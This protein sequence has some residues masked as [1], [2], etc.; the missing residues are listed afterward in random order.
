MAWVSPQALAAGVRPGLPVAEARSLAAAGPPAGGAP[1]ASRRAPQAWHWLESDPRAD[2]EELRAW[3]GWCERFSPLVALDETPEP[4][5]LLLDVSGCGPHFGG[6]A[7]LVRQLVGDLARQGLAARAALA[8]TW[9]AA[10]GWARHGPV[11]GEPEWRGAFPAG[12]APGWLVVDESRRAAFDLLPVAA[13]RL[14]SATL[15]RLAELGI[16]SIG[17]VRA[18][19]RA[20]LAARLGSEVLLRLDQAGG[21]RGEL[22]VSQRSDEPLVAELDFD[23][24]THD[25]RQLEAAWHEL[26]A[27]LR[28][29]L[30]ARGQQVRELVCRLAATPPVELALRL[31]EPTLSVRHLS[32][33][34]AL[35]LERRRLPPEVRG[36]A[37]E[38]TA[39]APLVDRQRWLVPEAAEPGGDRELAALCDRLTSRLGPAGVLRAELVAE[40]QPERACRYQ[41]PALAAAPRRNALGQTTAN[42]GGR[43]ARPTAGRRRAAVSESPPPDTEPRWRPLRLARRPRPLEVWAVAPGGPPER[44]R[45]AGRE[46]SLTQAW[47]PERIE[48]G[49]W[50]GTTVAR[51]YYQVEL[52][53]GERWWI[54][55]RAADGAWF[56]HGWFE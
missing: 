33:L 14:S 25:R 13:L 10:W 54:F 19:P 9:G 23:D 49:W 45:W 11:A 28:L 47:G 37:L 44:I 8:E 36:L 16:E 30:V 6:D 46:F 40:A 31:C 56:L 21:A 42:R 4:D 18:L 38:I 26:L 15:A 1:R 55:R 43:R 2:R 5:G 3:A 53:A 35:A 17:Q 22:P 41:E 7:A 24:P 50:R 29:R 27:R 34:L 20:A 51:D 52:P 48:T 12:L 39:T 32:E